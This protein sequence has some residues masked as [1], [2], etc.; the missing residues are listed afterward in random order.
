[1]RGS[2]LLP[3]VAAWLI[4][5]CS[6]EAVLEAG[7]EPKT[8]KIATAQKSSSA[9]QNTYPAS[10]R[11]VRSTDLAFQVSGRV[12]VWRAL[13]G[14]RFRKGDVIARLDDRSFRN[15]VTQAQAEF[16]NA[17]SEFERAERL[18]E[19][20]AI[21]QSVLESRLAER[22]VAAAALDSAEKDLSDTVLRAP[23][24]GTVGTTYIEEFQTVQA[25]SPILSLQSQQVEA[26]V[27]VP[28]SFVVNVP[29]V[30]S[31][32]A[33]VELDA[34]PGQEMP[35]RFREASGEADSST[36][37]FEAKFAFTPP[38][39]LLVLNGM[40]AR[41]KANAEFAGG[42]AQVPTGVAIPLS[43]VLHSEEKSFV[44]VIKPVEKTVTRREITLASSVGKQVVVK[45]GLKAG[46]RIVASG[47]A[48]LNEGDPV[49]E[50]QR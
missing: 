18:I 10:V 39:G 43:A 27:N 9:L 23:F 38:P 47:G 36:Q 31:I 16:R 50:W 22:E 14:T 7:P 37:T 25:Q 4:A 12:V 28:G 5:G 21:S 15:A 33:V 44:W 32:E 29:K 19:G 8:V 20:N 13:E 11:S 48:Y 45:S 26:V 1:M 49:R 40:T 6:G 30:R 35:A 41:L 46:E 42:M 17:Q 3:A 2:F 24:T 34:A